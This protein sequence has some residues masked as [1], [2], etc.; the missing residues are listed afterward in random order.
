MI[1]LHEPA[2][3]SRSGPGCAGS[4]GPGTQEDASRCVTA[5][6]REGA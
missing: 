2:M 4:S 6:R 3:V 5:L 1:V